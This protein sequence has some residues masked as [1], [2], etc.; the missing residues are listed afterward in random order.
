[1]SFWD[2]IK[3]IFRE[4][5][6]FGRLIGNY[7]IDLEKEDPQ[8]SL[9]KSIPILLIHGIFHN[10]SAWIYL[11]HRLKGEGFLS[12]FTINLANP[13]THTIE[14]YGK[15][16]A[17]KI[18]RIQEITRK[19]EIILV[20]HSM[21]GVISAYYVA[22]LDPNHDVKAIATIGSPLEGT[23]LAVL[24]IGL[25]PCLSQ[26]RYRNPFIQQVRRQLD[27]IKDIP[28]LHIAT[29]TDLQVRPVESALR[30]EAIG[31]DNVLI[32]GEGHIDLLYSSQVADNIL[33][34]IRN[35]SEFQIIP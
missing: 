10:S 12:V 2:L 5:K 11:R 7:F 13:F 35:Q 17:E 34:F 30:L 27:Q 4:L 33:G 18:K 14:D 25:S 31:A 28:M 22:N 24:G 26:M 8:T 20:G 21:G 23:H 16:I 6:G 9:D 15:Q 19:K 29:N 32:K 1:M 3:G